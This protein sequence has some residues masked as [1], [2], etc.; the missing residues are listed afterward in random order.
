[1][2]KFTELTDEAEI[3]LDASRNRLLQGVYWAVTAAVA[4]FDG[5]YVGSDPPLDLV[6][7]DRRSGKVAYKAGPYHG[8]E[9]IQEAQEAARSIRVIGIQGYVNRERL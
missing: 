1:M 8:A 6:V 7:R 5:S 9:A 3:S 4:L 2:K